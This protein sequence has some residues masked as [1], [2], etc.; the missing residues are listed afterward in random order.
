[1][2]GARECDDINGHR[3]IKYPCLLFMF[4][5]PIEGE[6]KTEKQTTVRLDQWR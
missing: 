5:F 4:I 6:I 2:V 3:K 1:M